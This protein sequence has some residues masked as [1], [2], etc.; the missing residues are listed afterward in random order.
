MLAKRVYVTQ[1]LV[2]QKVQTVYYP[3][4]SEHGR[5]EYTGKAHINPVKAT[6]WQETVAVENK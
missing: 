6:L 3:T 4:D 5:A 1:P 2:K